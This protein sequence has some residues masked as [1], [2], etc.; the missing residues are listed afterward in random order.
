[1][2]GSPT[3]PLLLRPRAVSR[4]W[5]GR[6]AAAFLDVPPI[7]TGETIG[8]W[9]LLSAR[10]GQPSIV[11]NAP[12]EDRSLPDVVAEDRETILGASIARRGRFPLLIKLL[13][14][15][16][17]LSVQVHPGESQSPGEGKTETWYILAARP[18]AS[19]WAGLAEGVTS[20]RFFACARDGG[21][22][23]P[24]LARY[25][26]RAGDLVHLHAGLI[27]AL[28]AG[29]VALEVQTSADTTYRI[30][31]F[32]REPARELHLERAQAVAAA[33]QRAV[34]PQPRPLNPSSPPRELLVAC[35]DYRIE[36][37]RL[38]APSQFAT[39]GGRFEILLPIGAAMRVAAEQGAVD[40]PR[41]HAVLVPAQTTDFVV[42]PVAPLEL[43]R[44]LPSSD[45]AP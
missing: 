10:D 7:A 45:E 16:S 6:A 39:L 8:E 24:L 15:Q 44:I 3:P 13:D 42:S 17:P 27:H 29:I 34:F 2:P 23:L 25:S 12:H 20:E 22:P 33:E 36:R 28:G 32:G 11:G 4:P 35:A 37:L 18:D 9:W 43:L 30:F 40:V 19:Y 21:D 38:T 31:D 1:M 5:G 26:A 41:G 14:T